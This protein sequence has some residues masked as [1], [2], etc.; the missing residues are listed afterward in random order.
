MS[1]N[2]S[3]MQVINDISAPHWRFDD[4]ELAKQQMRQSLGDIED[5]EVFGRTVLVAVYVRPNTNPTTGFVLASAKE[6]SADAWQGKAV[7]IIKVGPDA[8]AG[9]ESYVKAMY[10][11]KGVPQ[12]GDWVFM[13]AN[14]GDSMHLIG[15][16][17]ERPKGLDFN[18][19]PIDLY[20]WNGWPCRLIGDTSIIARA[21]KPSVI[22]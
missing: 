3:M 7:L 17:F 8:F 6:Q 20:D 19:R 1:S 16:G 21:N 22:L 15:D 9:D 2:K 14:D 18:K 13:R 5:I 10:G 4:Y 11:P 12:V